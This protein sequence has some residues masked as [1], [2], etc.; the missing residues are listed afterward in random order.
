[1]SEETHLRTQTLFVAMK[2][3]A[4]PVGEALIEKDRQVDQAFA[5]GN[6]ESNEL[7]QNLREIARIEGELRYAH[8]KHHL[9]MRSLLTPEQIA[10]Y[11][12]F[13]GYDHAAPMGHGGSG[14]QHSQ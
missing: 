1:L 10:S 9:A 11:D 2:Q 7:H 6:A 8:L 12:H 3:E 13:R 5:N 14:Q 4:V